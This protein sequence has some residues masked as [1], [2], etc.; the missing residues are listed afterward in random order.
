MSIKGWRGWAAHVA[1]NPVKG[2]PEEMREAFVALAPPP[3]DGEATTIGNVPCILYGKSERQPIV[4]LHGGGLVF[5]S[6]KTH[7]QLATTLA[8]HTGRSVLVPEYRLAPEHPWPAPLQDAIGVLDALPEP[9]DVVGDSAGGLLALHAALVRP[10]QV[11]RLALISPN[12][13]HTG[14]STTRVSNSDRDIMNN[15]DQDASLARLS[16]G[17]A[18]SEHPNASL[19]TQDLTH[20]PPVWITA[21]T[22]EVLLD[23]TLLLIRELGHA[24]VPCDA[25]IFR[26]LCHL[27]MLWPEALPQGTQV[28]RQLSDWLSKNRYRFFVLA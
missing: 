3:V 9:I 26:G 18:L 22:N 10:D 21:A 25:H 24:G 16:F 28:I 6:A 27:W 14:R 15:D 4:W 2:S 1:A 20:L 17:T 8:K 11:A 13:D 23:D 19:L 5:G 7:G 12:T